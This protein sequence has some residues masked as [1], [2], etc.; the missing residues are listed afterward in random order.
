MM[1]LDPEPKSNKGKILLVIMLIGAA[2]A[3]GYLLGHRRGQRTAEQ[4][5][6][7]QAAAPPVAAAPDPAA[8]PGAPVLPTPLPGSPTALPAPLPGQTTGAAPPPTPAVTTGAPS[9]GSQT[10]LPA[11]WALLTASLKG[12]LEETVT[13]SLPPES[14]GVAEQ[15]TQVV[16]RL[17]VWN[18][19]IARDGRPGDRLAVL[20]ETV[21]GTP[22]TGTTPTFSQEPVVHALRYD[23]QKLQKTLTAYRFKAPGATFARYYQSDGSELE[24]RLVD[25]PLNE[26][27]QVTSL[28]RDGRR[29]KG[30]D[31][32][33]PVGTPVLAPFD[34]VVVR[35][36]W[37]FGVN[38]NCLQIA[39]TKTGRHALFLHLEAVP[40]EMSV[41]KRFTK[42]EQIA[43]TGN[44]GRSTAPH[45]HYQLE[46]GGRVL[47][48][49]AIHQTKRI[50][51]DGEAKVAFEAELKRL[52]GLLSEQQ[53]AARP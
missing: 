1:N 20:Y 31:F 34:G 27:E 9:P 23:S 41:G 35:R 48:P 50:S 52:Q 51:L 32:K 19:Q 53:S 28:L 14:S 13:R 21:A 29:H 44:T 16:N 33:C 30:V 24:E 25:G 42:G 38:G 47:D 36:N 6:A 46:G 39:D 8:P 3:G 49:Y 26:Y 43:T 4:L 17:L 37:N 11:G 2:G 5:A 18:L 45:L 7:A 10:P 40:R 15:L 22:E 12:A